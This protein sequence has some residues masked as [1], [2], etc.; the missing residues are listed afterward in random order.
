VGHDDNRFSR[1]QIVGG[2]GIGLAATVVHPTFAENMTQSPIS[3]RLQDP[4]VKYPKPPSMYRRGRGRAL[5]ARWTLVP[6]M[7]KAVTTAMGV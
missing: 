1:R 6:A 3:D 5:R 4:T 7:A 2:L